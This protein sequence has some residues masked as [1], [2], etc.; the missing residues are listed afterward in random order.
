M[1][2]AQEAEAARDPLPAALAKVAGDTVTAVTAARA[3]PAEIEAHPGA[4]R[5][6]P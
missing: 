2:D 5:L 3:P 6:V 4:Q 1:T